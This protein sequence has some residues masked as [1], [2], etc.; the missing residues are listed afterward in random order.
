MEE[1][2]GRKK[3]SALLIEIFCW[4]WRYNNGGI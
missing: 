2:C 4:R 3:D 1:D